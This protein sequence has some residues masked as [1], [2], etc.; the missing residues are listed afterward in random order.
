[1]RYLSFADPELDLYPVVLLVPTI[2]KDDIRKHYLDPFTLDQN[3]LLVVETFKA[4]GKKK[5][6]ASEIKAWFAEELAPTTTSI[7]PSLS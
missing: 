2:R 6:S 1:M 4:V 7:K 3:E 5:P